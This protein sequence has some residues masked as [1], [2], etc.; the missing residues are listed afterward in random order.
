VPPYLVLCCAKPAVTAFL[1]FASKAEIA[2]LFAA[3]FPPV[4][5]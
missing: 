3:M 5:G 1:R 4:S 2:V